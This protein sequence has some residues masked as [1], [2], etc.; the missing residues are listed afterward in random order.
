ME[1]FVHSGN[2]SLKLLHSVLSCSLYVRGCA[3]WTVKRWQGFWSMACVT[4]CTLSALKGK[5]ANN[6]SCCCSLLHPALCIKETIIRPVNEIRSFLPNTTHVH[7]TK[8]EHHTCVG[9]TASRRVVT[10][11]DVKPALLRGLRGAKR[12]HPHYIAGTRTIESPLDKRKQ[13]IRRVKIDKE[14]TRRDD[15]NVTAVASE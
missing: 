9:S 2:F 8:R 10:W 6:P 13:R 5:C 12:L 11:L 14:T 15:S 7:K 1:K 3:F 4:H